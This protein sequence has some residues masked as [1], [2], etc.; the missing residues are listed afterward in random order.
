MTAVFV[1]LRML[2][3]QLLLLG[4]MLFYCVCHV[5]AVGEG[6]FIYNTLTK[7]VQMIQVFWI[8][9]CGWISVCCVLKQHSPFIIK[10][11]EDQGES[12]YTENVTKGC[13]CHVGK[14][15]LNSGKIL[16]DRFS[17]G[18][19]KYKK[20][21]FNWKKSCVTLANEW[22]QCPEILC[23]HRFFKVG[24]Q[25]CHPQRNTT[26]KTMSVNS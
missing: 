19:R 13:V 9:H 16:N 14:E 6:I 7:N 3:H 17:I 23:C 26:F 25:K 2:G 24:C 20:L 12:V 22:K 8:W 15:V 5:Y 1:R 21:C 11:W 4:C 18:Q 10:V